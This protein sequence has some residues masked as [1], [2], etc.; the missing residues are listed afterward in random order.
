MNIRK[1]A[2]HN[3]ALLAAGALILSGCSSEAG[4]SPASSSGDAGSSGPAVT[5]IS[6]ATAETPWL[7]GYQDIVALYEQETGVKVNLQVFPFDGLLTQQANAAQTGSND[8]DVFQLNEQWVGQF[9]DNEWVQALTDVDPG[10]D[11]DPALL[12]FD[13]L[14]RWDA[15]ARSTSPTGIP[16][17]LPING[18]IH[19]FMYLKSA[20]E[21]LGLPIPTTWEEVEATGIAAQQAG[22]TEYGFVPRGRTPSYDFSALLFSYG[23]AWFVDE[24]AGN[25]QPAINSPE[26]RTA[27]EQYKAL[28]DIGPEAPQTIAQAEAVSLMQSGE[29]LQSALVAAVATPLENPEASLVAGDVGYEVLPG[30]TPVSGAWTVAIPAGLPDDR[31]QAAYDFI[32][33]LTSQEAMQAWVEVGGVITRSDV[34]TD[35]PEIL[36]I[37]ESENLIR[38]GFRYP[39]TPQFLEATQPVIGEYLAGVISVDEALSQME[40]NLLEVVE[41]AGFLQ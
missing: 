10:F 37:V 11:W 29:V 40:A 36:K 41:T 14:G 15:S 3:V 19:L 2:G 39:F 20:Y 38:A 1:L 26:G 24:R 31:T 5:E 9:Y 17:S 8:F 32:T 13:G 23:G 21:E 27:L 30:R 33:W 12:E 16:Y 35:R 34:Q 7:G 28:A 22:L 18:N 25:F 6:V 4:T